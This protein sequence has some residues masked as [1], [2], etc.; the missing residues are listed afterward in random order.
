[1]GQLSPG[2][3][4]NAHSHLSGLSNCTKCHVLGNRVPNEKCLD[5]HSEIQQRITSQKGYHSSVDVR[6]KTC[7]SCHSEHN[8]KN[9]QLTRLDITTFD[10]NLTGYQL[11]VPHA[12][13][14]CKAC[15]TNVHISD[16]NILAK[17]NTYL[18]LSTECLSCHADYHQQTLSPICLDCHS[19]DAF[20]PTSKFS[21]SAT[22]FPLI[23]KHKSV[24]CI[25]CH[26]VETI[27]GTKFQEFRGVLFSNC[28]NCHEDPHQN[29]FGQ[30][31][32]QCHSE[33]SFST[34]KGVNNFDHTKTGFSLEGK[35]LAVDCKS[36]HKT[37]L[38]D[39]LK[40]NL[41]TDCHTDYHTGQ[42]ARNGVSPDCSQC[43]SVIGFTRF[44]YTIDQHN[45]AVFPLKG[46]HQAVACLECHKKQEKWSFREIG[47]DCKDCHTD[48]HK[49]FIQPKYYPASNCRECH[50]ETRWT[51]VTFNHSVTNFPLTGAHTDKNCRLCH[52]KA[53][54][55]GVVH[56]KFS[57]LSRNCAECH[58][59]NHNKQFDKN[60]FT[61]C[62]ECHLTEKW[63]PSNFD[64]NNAA[65][66]LDGKHVDVACAK[67]HKP[68]KVGST[69]FVKY[70][71]NEFKC[72][73]CH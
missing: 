35:H 17:K 51:Q 9:F 10:H 30:N 31:C 1:M 62:T 14:D 23:G 54:P 18:G 45:A 8:G 46:S 25:E 5:C 28:T 13:E 27:N 72:E 41:C 64:H 49:S 63:A 70:K 20:K 32:R 44:N 65:F 53:D 57:G 66:K 50:T 11:S 15:H 34:I 69:V 21:H 47:I 40:H 36:C 22:K 43:H 29:Q 42:F 16:K 3:L 26:K 38:T 67:C 55:V 59:D 33:E 68:E 48:V 60:G 39:P 12:R 19:P 24:E 6:G 73:S 52:F 37:K 56:Q 2:D 4:S 58:S 7:F 61:D 71:L